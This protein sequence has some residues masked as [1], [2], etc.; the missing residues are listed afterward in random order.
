MTSDISLLSINTVEVSLSKLFSSSDDKSS[1]WLPK[2]L[3]HLSSRVSVGFSL[4]C[5]TGEEKRS[6]LFLLL[7]PP[8]SLDLLGVFFSPFVSKVGA[9][10]LK[11]SAADGSGPLG[12]GTASKLTD[13]CRF[14][15]TISTSSLVDGGSVI[16]SCLGSLSN[17]VDGF[18]NLN[19]GDDCGDCPLVG[20]CNQGGLPKS[21]RVGEAVLELLLLPFTN[22]DRPGVRW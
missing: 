2:V 6:S 1:N 12:T 20:R 7:F 3:T 22:T 19:F 15:V 14:G 11:S 4:L 13:G 5:G 9:E 8:L 10:S 21:V 16:A 17:I 18:E